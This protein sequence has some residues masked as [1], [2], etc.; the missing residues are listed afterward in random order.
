MERRTPSSDAR[1]AR[2]G[3]A[4][5]TLAGLIVIMTVIMIVVAYTVPQQWSMIRARERDRQTIFAMKQYARAIREFQRKNNVLPSSL[6]QL[7]EAREP[8]YIRGTTGFINDPV[9]G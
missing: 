8:R 7:K 4:G 3:E 6:K 9:S 5:F 2:A 1:T